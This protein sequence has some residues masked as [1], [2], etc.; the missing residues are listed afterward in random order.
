MG[1]I[2]C[3]SGYRISKSY[4]IQPENGYAY[5]QIDFLEECPVCGHCV[6]QITRIDDKNNI[7]ICRKTNLKA[8]ALYEKLKTKIIYEKDKENYCTNRKSN[9]Y[10]YYNEFGKKKKCYSNLSTMKLGL[11]ENKNLE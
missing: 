8:K 5:A 10:L 1:Y 4:A 2:H 6:V 7:S 3:C 11:F 9:F